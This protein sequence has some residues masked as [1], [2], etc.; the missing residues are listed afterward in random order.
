MVNEQCDHCNS[1]DRVK[2]RIVYDRSRMFEFKSP[3]YYEHVCARC[4]GKGTLLA[5]IAVAAVVLGLGGAAAY[6]HFTGLLGP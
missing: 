5:L 6:I 3:I 4:R 1:T 2:R